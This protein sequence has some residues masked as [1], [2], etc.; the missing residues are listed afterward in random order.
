[1]SFFADKAAVPDI[2]SRERRLRRMDREM[3]SPQIPINAGE[4][5]GKYSADA[6]TTNVRKWGACDIVAA[7]SPTNC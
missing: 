4:A 2:R 3:K 5:G 1:M 7:L 6:A